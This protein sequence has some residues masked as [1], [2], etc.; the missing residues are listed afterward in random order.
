[1]EDATKVSD[2]RRERVSSFDW[3]TLCDCRVCGGTEPR[4]GYPFAPFVIVVVFSLDGISSS[5]SRK[6]GGGDAGGGVCA[7]LSCRLPDDFEDCLPALSPSSPPSSSIVLR[8]SCD[9]CLESSSRREDLSD[10]DERLSVRECE[11]R[12]CFWCS[13]TMRRYMDCLPRRP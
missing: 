8:E 4:G 5:G 11:D 3:Y 7:L 1:M 2:D 12:C 13:E 9:R 10:F 6:T